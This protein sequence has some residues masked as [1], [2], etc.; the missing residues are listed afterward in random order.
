MKTSLLSIL[1]KVFFIVIAI[2]FL[3][4]PIITIQSVYEVYNAAYNYQKLEEI[5][6]KQF[7]KGNTFWG[8][9]EISKDNKDTVGLVAYTSAYLYRPTHMWARK[10]IK[11]YIPDHILAN[12]GNNKNITLLLDPTIIDFEF[13]PAYKASFLGDLGFFS[14]KKNR[15]PTVDLSEKEDNGNR[16]IAKGIMEGEP[17]F[18]KYKVESIKPL[19]LSTKNPAFFPNPERL[20][21]DYTS[22]FFWP[23]AHILA[24]I[25]L[26][27]DI[28]VISAFVKKILK[29]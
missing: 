11:T 6:V 4:V 12:D 9:I 5:D 10:D 14:I 23:F 26:V 24:G 20:W 29:K 16:Y 27:I 18:A 21:K 22:G 3:M 19:V 13:L 15:L 8:Q 17:L 28:F 25:F 1:I 7:D 2:L